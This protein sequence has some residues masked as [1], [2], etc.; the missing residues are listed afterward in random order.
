VTGDGVAESLCGDQRDVPRSR[1]ASAPPDG[2]V[3]RPEL[4]NPREERALLD[5]F[6]VAEF[7]VIVMKGVVAR[8][9][10]L[11]FGSGYDYDRRTP[12]SGAPPIPPWLQPAREHA[13]ALAGVPADSLVQ[14]LVQHYPVG[15]PIGWHRDSPA[16]EL[17][18]G[19]SLLAPAA[20]RLRRG[21]AGE[22]EQWEV[23]LEPRSGYVL[24]GEA[25][26]KWEHHVPPAKSDRYSITFRTLR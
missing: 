11:R 6:E 24:S 16:Y 25:R 26:W 18:A 1:R 7:S 20:L 14:A 23:V 9:T 5:Q 12:T 4:L 17:V 13:A 22:R 3:Y 19:I 15:A 8:R 21:P 2:L 10:A